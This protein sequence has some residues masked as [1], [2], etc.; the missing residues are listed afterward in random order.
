M[1]FRQ[2][3]LVLALP[4]LLHMNSAIASAIGGEKMS[5]SMTVGIRCL[6]TREI[7]THAGLIRRFTE[8]VIL[9]DLENVGR[10]LVYVQWDN[11]ISGYVY[12]VEIEPVKSATNSLARA[13]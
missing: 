5:D 9:Y 7:R 8:G 6:A 3:G 2:A 1:I 12:P 11:G 10:R 4:L 13:S